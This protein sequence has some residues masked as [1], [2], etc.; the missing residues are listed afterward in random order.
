MSL[1]Q[2][3]Y[4]PTDSLVRA[5]RN[6][7]RHSKK[8]IRQIAKSI[9]EFGFMNPVLCDPSRRIVAGHGR[10]DAAK[11][12]GM[13]TVPVL[14]AHNLTP[15]QLR[16]YAI[17]ENRLCELGGWSTEDLT[18]DCARVRLSIHRA[19]GTNLSA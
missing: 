5:T 18:R 7:R 12:L 13:A 1:L 19:Q 14:F 16:L 2:I 9:K 8:Q 11:L 6:A 17:A 10:V 4:E 3:Q 15:E